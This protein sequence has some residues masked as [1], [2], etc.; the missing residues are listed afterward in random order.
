MTISHEAQQW[1]TDNNERY[2]GA[3]DSFPYLIITN[4]QHHMTPFLIRGY[5]PSRGIIYPDGFIGCD[6]ANTAQ[7]HLN[8]LVV[9]IM[10]SLNKR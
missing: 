6:T 9:K 10:M 4:R 1:L 5:C 8:K 2:V 7:F 3:I